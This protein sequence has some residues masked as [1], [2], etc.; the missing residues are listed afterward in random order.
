MIF[1]KLELSVKHFLQNIKILTLEIESETHRRVQCGL[2]ISNAD[3]AGREKME[4]GP[5]VVP[6]LAGLALAPLAPPLLSAPS[7]FS[8][9]GEAARSLLNT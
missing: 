8:L 3:E 4:E 1:C 2:V 9:E 7:L 5:G 6:F